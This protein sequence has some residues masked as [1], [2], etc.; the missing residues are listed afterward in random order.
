MI[1]I[2]VGCCW[3]EVNLPVPLSILMLM[4]VLIVVFVVGLPIEICSIGIDDHFGSWVTIV[5]WLQLVIQW[6]PLIQSVHDLL[7][8]FRPPFSHYVNI[9][10]KIFLHHFTAY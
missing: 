5:H 4:G 9:L 1:R 10:M 6:T 3:D 8:F 2:V 7:D